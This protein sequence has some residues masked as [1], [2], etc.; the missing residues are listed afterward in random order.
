MLSVRIL[1]ILQYIYIYTHCWSN[2]IWFYRIGYRMTCVPNSRLIRPLIVSPIRQRVSGRKL[3]SWEHHINKWWM[4]KIARLHKQLQ[5][6][7]LTTISCY[8]GWSIT[9]TLANEPVLSMGSFIPR[10]TVIIECF[11]HWSLLLSIGK[12]QSLTMTAF[13]WSQCLQMQISTITTGFC[14]T[15]IVD[16]RSEVPGATMNLWHGRC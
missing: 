2:A 12:C 10:C 3:V 16:D 7:W 1:R 9:K 14:S 4:T 11:K 15:I 8:H 13:D 5:Q 6:P